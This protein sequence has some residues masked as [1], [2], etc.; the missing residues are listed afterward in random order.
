MQSV[1]SAGM[2]LSDHDLASDRNRAVQFLLGMLSESSRRLDVFHGQPGI[3]DARSL[4]L[5][6]KLALITSRYP[7]LAESCENV[8]LE[9][10]QYHEAFDL[11]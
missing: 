4:L 7:S 5:E 6:R 3:R 11:P 1:R 10:T 2:S 8:K 9:R